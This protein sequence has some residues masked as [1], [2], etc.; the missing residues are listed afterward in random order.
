MSFALE[1]GVSGPDAVVT[2]AHGGGGRTA[3]TLLQTLILPA[4]GIDPAAP[5]LD[6]AVLDAPAGCRLVFSTDG[7]VV[8]PWSFPGGDLG[9][10]AVYGTVNDLAM[11]GAR[12][13][14]LSL[15]LILEEGTP[16]DTVRAVLESMARAGERAGV[17]V[18]T[19]DTKVVE[20][21]RGDG[22]YAAVAGIGAV[23]EWAVLGPR[24]VRPGDAVVL[25][26]DVGRHGV[27]VLSV[28]EGLAF[29]SPV[30]SDCA[31]V[32]ELVMALL[33]AGVEVHALRDP[34]RGGLAA[35]LN[36]MA[37]DAG[38]AITVE[39]AA[40]P[41]CEGVEGACALLGLD[42]FSMA[43]EGRLVAFVPEAEADRAVAI[44][45]SHP[46]GAGATPIGWVEAAPAGRVTLVTPLGTRRIM[47]FLSGEAL[48]RIC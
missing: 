42:P 48:P 40:V 47:D 6:A 43:C 16:L 18:V 24:E 20:R 13:L 31:P 25:S 7:A 21:G 35:A 45:R 37:L 38:V 28:R 36:E 33:E 15:S 5:G 23:G 19:G 14:A 11:M 46:L 2:L 10:L 9:T 44:L 3:R 8:R 34:T 41:V 17:R 4:L 1:C 39:E 32:T 22:V 30:E 29:E 26:G 12:P 27:A